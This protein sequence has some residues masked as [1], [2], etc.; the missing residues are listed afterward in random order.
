MIGRGDSSILVFLMVL[1]SILLLPM[2]ANAAGGGPLLLIFNGSGYLLCFLFSIAIEYFVLSLVWNKI[3]KKLLC[4]VV[5]MNIV[6]ALVVGLIL[7]VII[8]VIGAILSSQYHGSGHI[9]MA[10]STWFVEGAELNHISPWAALALFWLLFPVVI[11]VE[12]RVLCV[13]KGYFSKTSVE[14]TIQL[15]TVFK[16]NLF[17]NILVFLTIV[18]VWDDLL[19]K[20][21]R[22]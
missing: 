22:H 13:M 9:I 10:A 14:P 17:S 18:L 16:A 2:D 19:F 21:W 5:A 20:I 7:P 12:Y 1:L 8:A 15:P 4:I 11:Y 6:S 3:R